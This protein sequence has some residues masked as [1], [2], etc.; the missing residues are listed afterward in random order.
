MWAWPKQ[1][2]M[3]VQET[4]LLLALNQ[5]ESYPEFHS[6]QALSP[7]NNLKELEKGPRESNE[8]QP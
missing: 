7:G 8:I 1:V 2:K 3:K 4:F 5:K 6:F